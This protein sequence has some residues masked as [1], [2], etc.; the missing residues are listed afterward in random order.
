MQ[1][2]CTHDYGD[3]H[4]WELYEDID[5]ILCNTFTK[6][7]IEDQEWYRKYKL[8]YFIEILPEIDIGKTDLEI[9]VSAL[10][11]RHT[12]LLRDKWDIERE[13]NKILELIYKFENLWADHF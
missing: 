13:I 11:R 9:K 5:W 7:P 1:I 2:L 12:K 4:E 3:I 6:E 8:E 10:C